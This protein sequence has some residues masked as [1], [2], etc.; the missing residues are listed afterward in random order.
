[1]IAPAS[2][3][4]DAAIDEPGVVEGQIQR[5]TVESFQDP[6]QQGLV[7]AQDAL[8]FRQQQRTKHGRNRER[9]DQGCSQSDKIGESERLEQPAFNA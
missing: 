7:V 1:M 2:S 6:N 4:T 9:H 3:T 5:R 8:G